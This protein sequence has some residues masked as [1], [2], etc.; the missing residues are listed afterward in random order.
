MAI[1]DIAIS[2]D[3]KGIRRECDLSRAEQ[4]FGW[5]SQPELQWLAEQASRHY[6]I[7]EL[8][9]FLG[10][11]TRAMADNTPGILWALDRWSRMDYMPDLAN[12]PWI[13]FQLNLSDHLSSGKVQALLLDHDSVHAFSL[14]QLRKLD[15][16]FIDGD[17]S[18]D[19][20]CRDIIEW[21]PR[22][23]PGGLLCGHDAHDANWP[24]VD[25]ALALLVPDAQYVPGTALWYKVQ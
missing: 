19:A 6:L 9:S 11:S 17:H 24:G 3:S 13:Q 22:I 1:S 15:M 10:R 23:A 2:A 14:P 16:C 25:Q 12:E 20:V 7:V 18:F 21:T 4:I 8:G 5:M